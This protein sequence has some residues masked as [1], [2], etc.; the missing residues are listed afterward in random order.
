MVSPLMS[1]VSGADASD[2]W[3]CSGVEKFAADQVITMSLGVDGCSFG[4]VGLQLPLKCFF[5]LDLM[6]EVTE[7][8]TLGLFLLD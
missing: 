7:K 2:K 4:Q 8:P 5:F 6:E 3:W 1:D